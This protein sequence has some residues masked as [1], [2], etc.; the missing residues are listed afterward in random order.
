MPSVSLEFTLDRVT[1]AR[2]IKWPVK[3]QK[4]RILLLCVL[5]ESLLRKKHL[6][7]H[8]ICVV[9][10]WKSTAFLFQSNEARTV[11][12]ARK[13]MASQFAPEEVIF[14]C[15]YMPN[16]KSITVMIDYRNFFINKYRVVAARRLSL[17]QRWAR[18]WLAATG[19]C[20]P[21]GALAARGGRAPGGGGGLP[22]L[23][24]VLFPVWAELV[25]SDQIAAP[26]PLSIV[27]TVT[28]GPHL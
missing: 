4:I 6:Y 10:D 17:A 15:Q 26:S 2:S 23:A 27:S 5:Y 24:G 3:I 21:M 20:R 1:P 8:N 11:L 14:L 25:S 22:V 12:N 28:P 7:V 13:L 18:L 16:N 19:W 9:F